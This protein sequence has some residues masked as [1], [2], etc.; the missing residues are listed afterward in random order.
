MSLNYK[1]R[2]GFQKD[3]SYI[4]KG[5]HIINKIFQP[6]VSLFQLRKCIQLHSVQKAWQLNVKEP[7]VMEWKGKERKKSG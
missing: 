7:K 5:Q 3:C 2:R 4:W 1:Q 6:N